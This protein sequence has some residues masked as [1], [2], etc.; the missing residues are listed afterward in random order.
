MGIRFLSAISGDSWQSNGVAQTIAFP[1][2]VWERG[3]VDYIW[4]T[5]TVAEIKTAIEGLSHDEVKKIA[6]WLEDFQMTI[7]ASAEVFAQLDADE[8]ET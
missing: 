8:E 1:N 2:R 5:K 6:A 7:G 4:R 3:N